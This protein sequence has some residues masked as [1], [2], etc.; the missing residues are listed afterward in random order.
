M[1]AMLEI[2][3]RQRLQG[4]GTN[5]LDGRRKENRGEKS[6]RCSDKIKEARIKPHLPKLHPSQSR[7]L[8]S[9]V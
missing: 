9:Q 5:L 1:D 3:K 8:L 6:P 4:K 7:V 2:N